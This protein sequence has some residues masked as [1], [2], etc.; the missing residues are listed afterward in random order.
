MTDDSA[1]G[2]PPVAADVAAGA[3]DLLP[4]RLRKRVDAAVAKMAG[5]PVEGVPGGVRVRVDEESWVMLRVSGGVV[6]AEGDAVCGCLLAPACLHRAAILAACPVAEPSEILPLDRAPSTR[7]PRTPDS[8][9]DPA[10]G[11]A[12]GATGALTQDTPARPAIED[13]P[14]GTGA[15]TQDTPARRAIG[16]SPEAPGAL[17]QDTPARPAIEDGP[18]GTGA[19]T[20]AGPGRGPAPEPPLLKRRRGWMGEPSLLTHQGGQVGEPPLLTHQEGQVGEPSLPTHQEGQ[21]GE[22]ARD[23]ARPAIED[24]PRATG[25]RTRT[26]TQGTSA[27]PAMDQARGPGQA[28][29]AHPVLG[30]VR[31]ALVGVL[32]RGVGGGGAVQRAEVLHAAHSARLAGFPLPAAAAVRVARRL[33]EAQGNDPAFRLSEL[34]AELTGLL[35]LLDRPDDAAAPPRRSYQPAKPL[36]LFG[37]FTEPVVTASGY[38]GATAYGCAPD[39]TLHTVSDIM[40]GPPARA[41]R[42]SGSPLPGGCALPLREWGDGG[43][44]ILTDP[45][46]SPDGRIG[47]GAGVRSVRAAGAAWHEPPLDAL[48]RR[49]PADQLTAALDWSAEPAGV[50]RAGG[51]LLFLTG[52]VTA[53]GF[54]AD[55]GPV[56]RLLAPDERAELAYAENL[57]LLA[58]RP[59]LRL[60]LI[61]RLAA[62]RPGAVRALAAA[63]TGH[64][65]EQVRA[66]L[67]LRRLNR[68]LI[69]AP[70]PAPA[71]PTAPS[72]PPP[73]LPMELDLLRRAVDRA[74]A[75]GR[76]VTAASA[77]GELPRRLGAAGLAT[78]AECA[79]ALAERAADRRHDGLGRLLP[80]DPDAFATAWLAASLY[81]S[82]ATRALLPAAWSAGGAGEPERTP[83]AVPETAGDSPRKDSRKDPR[84][85]MRRDTAR[86][87]SPRTPSEPV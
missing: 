37:L 18:R 67:G 5:R 21:A 50:R 7:S 64:D 81:V 55:G 84:R 1:P 29:A 42:A 51:D 33:T 71:T 76:A 79:R 61:A 87:E 20:Q 15:R 11:D 3:L 41:V 65:G 10:T 48:W 49:P 52:T 32:V 60:R 43:A 68:S 74:V 70:P 56:L 12:P 4:A 62:D 77:D 58:S 6:V 38:A 28:G 69:P 44:V 59:G 13:G 39:G 57:R 30:V 72:P 66:D 40:P 45:T 9:A 80:A 54:R 19:R 25:T 47:A 78:G 63:W 73:A 31:R 36:R 34:T 46:V 85:D 24:G 14:R 8:P 22:P 83:E 75:G 35:D 26:R 27:R 53:E 16:D 23:Q 2:L 82:A 17:T 86:T